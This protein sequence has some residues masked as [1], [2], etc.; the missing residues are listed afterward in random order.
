MGQV[1]FPGVGIEDRSAALV[2]PVDLLFAEEEDAAQDQF[3]DAVGMGFGVGECKGGAPGSA[4][5]LPA[6]DG[7]GSRPT[8]DVGRSYGRSAC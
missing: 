7:Q 1:R 2:E 5:D 4:E 8:A 6:V 3:G